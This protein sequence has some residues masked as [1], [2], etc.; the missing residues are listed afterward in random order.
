MGYLADLGIER[1]VWRRLHCQDCRHR[2]STCEVTLE[3][4]QAVSSEMEELRKMA[5]KA[6]VM[7]ES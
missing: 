4:M 1:Y 7:W 5:V 3:E 2:W 6:G